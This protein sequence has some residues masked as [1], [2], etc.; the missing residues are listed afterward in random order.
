MDAAQAENGFIRVARSRKT[1]FL[2][3]MARD[4]PVTGAWFEADI[5]HI[6]SQTLRAEI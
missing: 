4:G 3:K 2:P 1:L 6:L 5:C